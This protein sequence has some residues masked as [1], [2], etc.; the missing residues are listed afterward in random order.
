MLEMLSTVK[1]L[2]VQF[3]FYVKAISGVH[4]Y[5]NGYGYEFNHFVRV[6]TFICENLKFEWFLVKVLLVLLFS[7]KNLR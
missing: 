5:F 2:N 6:C 1:V 7:E 4:G 3:Y